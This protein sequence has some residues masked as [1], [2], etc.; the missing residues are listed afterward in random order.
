MSQDLLAWVFT[1][2]LAL[3]HVNRKKHADRPLVR[4]YLIFLGILLLVPV[5]IGAIAVAWILT[6]GEEPQPPRILAAAVALGLVIPA[7]RYA[8]RIIREAPTPDS[9]GDS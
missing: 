2:A 8:N 7:W 5:G 4:T 1:L 6:V 3:W 9:E